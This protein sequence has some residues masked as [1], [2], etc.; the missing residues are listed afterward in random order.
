VDCEE[1]L[2]EQLSDS[3]DCGY[4][5]ISLAGPTRGHPWSVSGFKSRWT[6]HIKVIPEMKTAHP[7]LLRHTFASELTD[8][9]ISPGVIQE[10]LGHRSPNSTDVYTHPHLQS[11]MQAATALD[12]WRAQ[13]LERS[14]QS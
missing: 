13:H 8:A 6:R 12:T 11:L 10:L 2:Y 4:L 9:G 3:A 7:H 5:L 1:P 14:K